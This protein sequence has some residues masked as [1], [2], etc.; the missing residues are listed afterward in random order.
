MNKIISY[1]V[2]AVVLVM[3]VIGFIQG[4]I[5]LGLTLMV[6]SEIVIRWIGN[7]QKRHGAG[8]VIYAVG[9]SVLSIGG[10]IWVLELL[11]KESSPWWIVLVIGFWLLALAV[12]ILDILARVLKIESVKNI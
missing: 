1:A 10:T 3:L 5:N 2:D 4:E 7:A 9:M 8:I 11:Q 6:V 12:Y